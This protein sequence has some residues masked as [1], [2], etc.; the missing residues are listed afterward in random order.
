M[1]MNTGVRKSRLVGRGQ[2]QP[3]KMTKI[4]HHREQ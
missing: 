2:G 4:M 3:K 1:K